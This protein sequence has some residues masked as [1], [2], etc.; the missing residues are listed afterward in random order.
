MNGGAPL[1]VARDGLD[2]KLGRM[3][4]LYLDYNVAMRVAEDLTAAGHDVIHVRDLGTG[5]A[6]DGHHLLTAAQQRRV[7]VTHDAEDFRLLHDAWQRWASAWSIDVSHAGILIIPQRNYLAERLV[8]L[9]EEMLQ[10][11]QPLTN[12]LF[13]WQPSTGWQ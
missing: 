3:S 5:R 1:F 4:K 9:I 12:R 6:T 10:S 13:R 8:A 7:L 11:R 2:T